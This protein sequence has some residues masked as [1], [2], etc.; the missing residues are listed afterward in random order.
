MKVT[1]GNIE[2]RTRKEL[3][4]KRKDQT[5][6]EEGK[7]ESKGIT[8]GTSITF[9]SWSSSSLYGKKCTE[10]GR[11]EN[12][13]SAVTRGGTVIDIP[14]RHHHCS[15]KRRRTLDRSGRANMRS[16]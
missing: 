13:R 4:K 7:Y 10:S 12:V 5:E 9:V 3:G 2:Q 6:N 11:S 15:S 14:C 8:G 16:A 1:F